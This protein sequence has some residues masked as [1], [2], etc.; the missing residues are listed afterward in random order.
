[1]CPCGLFFPNDNFLV[2]H[3]R[4]RARREKPGGQHRTWLASRPRARGAVKLDCPLCGTTL[5]SR[6]V[7]TRFVVLSFPRWSYRRKF[8]GRYWKPEL[9]SVSDES[10]IL[11]EVQAEDD[12]TSEKHLRFVLQPRPGPSYKITLPWRRGQCKGTW[13]REA[14]YLR[15]VS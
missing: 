10:K 7:Y 5:G 6:C 2:K 8:S 14:F 13:W 9:S 12:F 1:M 11:S 15:F 4:N 3:A